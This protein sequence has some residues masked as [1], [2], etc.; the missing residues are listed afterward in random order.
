M[1]IEQL[2]HTDIFITTLVLICLTGLI[3]LLLVLENV[4]YIYRDDDTFKNEKD[5]KNWNINKGKDTRPIDFSKENPEESIVPKSLGYHTEE[6][7]DVKGIKPIMGKIGRV[8]SAVYEISDA[9]LSIILKAI[10]KKGIEF[11]YTKI[12]GGN[13]SI[14]NK[15]QI[16]NM[17][18]MELISS[19]NKEVIKRNLNKEHPDVFFKVL[20][21]EFKHSKSHKNHNQKIIQ[22]PPTFRSFEDAGLDAKLDASMIKKFNQ[23]NDLEEYSSKDI[24]N[25][26]LDTNQ[27]FVTIGRKGTYQDFTIYININIEDTEKIK[28]K[29]NT[30]KVYGVKNKEVNKGVSGIFSSKMNNTNDKKPSKIPSEYFKIPYK[31]KFVDE[32]IRNLAH[33][34]WVGNHK[35]FVLINGTDN[36]E[37]K[38]IN[39]QLYCESHHPEYEQIG[40]WDAPCQDDKECPYNKANKNYNN[41]FGGCDKKTGKCDMPFGVTRFG[42]KR[43]TKDEPLCYNCGKGMGDKCCEEQKNDDI[44]KSPDYVFMGDLEIRGL[45]IDT[46]RKNGCSSSLLG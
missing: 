37:I 38:G 39:N 9:D 19:I 44:K 41:N 24:S 33:D 10:E 22:D 31:Q 4:G 12:V 32:Y 5:L 27:M 13:A 16:L 42:Y 28:I 6:T 46:L 7:L 45:Q 26:S 25:F 15:K 18:L 1:P 35:C 40:V 36:H 21:Y 14:E 43:T 23:P 29:F 2:L 34:K 20:D 17:F 11:P 3:I 30:L 8:Y